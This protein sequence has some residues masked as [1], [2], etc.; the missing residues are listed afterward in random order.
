MQS[1]R[2]VCRIQESTESETAKIRAETGLDWFSNEI[3]EYSAPA[4]SA[5]SVRKFE[6]RSLCASRIDG[7]LSAVVVQFRVVNFNG[8]INGLV[9][10]KCIL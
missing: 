3:R 2:D 9:F 4:T 6:S 5:E 1:E 10:I 8:G 7:P